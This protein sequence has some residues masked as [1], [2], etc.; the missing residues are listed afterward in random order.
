MKLSPRRLS[1]RAEIALAAAAG[2]AIALGLDYWVNSEGA[3][4]A[5]AGAIAGGAAAGAVSLTVASLALSL[6]FRPLTRRGAAMIG[7]GVGASLSLVLPAVLAV[8]G[9]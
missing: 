1:P 6:Y 3:T 8:F 2:A 4:F 5:R 7:F 9:L